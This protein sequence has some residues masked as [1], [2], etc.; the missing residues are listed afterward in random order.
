MICSHSFAFQY[1]TQHYLERLRYFVSLFLPRIAMQS[2]V[3]P[4]CNV[5]L[6][7]RL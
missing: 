5:C 2:A 7:V 1:V 6:S 3:M 4:Q